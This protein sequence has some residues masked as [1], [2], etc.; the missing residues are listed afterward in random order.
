MKTFFISRATA[1][2][3]YIHILLLII[4]VW[5]FC[6]NWFLDWIPS[7]MKYTKHYAGQWIVLSILVMFSNVLYSQCHHLSMHINSKDSGFTI[8]WWKHVFKDI[9]KINACLITIEDNHFLWVYK[10]VRTRIGWSNKFL[11]ER[12]AVTLDMGHF[13]LQVCI[14]DMNKSLL[15]WLAQPVH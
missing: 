2:S 14:T 9:Y 15:W 6:M 12:I 5:W 4:V 13:P 1:N 7:S 10:E 8:E 3:N 11:P